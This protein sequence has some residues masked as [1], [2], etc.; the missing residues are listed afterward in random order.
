VADITMCSD[1]ECPLR[2]NCYRATAKENKY[3][4]SYFV[5]SPR[6][7]K[8]NCEYYWPKETTKPTKTKKGNK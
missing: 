2:K 6:E 3:R 1:L 5:G 7:G 8:D 4:Q